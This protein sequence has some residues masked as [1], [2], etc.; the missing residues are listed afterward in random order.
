MGI[1][2][3][4][5]SIQPFLGIDPFETITTLKGETVRDKEGRRTFKVRLG[6]KNYF[7]KYHRGIGWKEIA[8][9][10]AQLRFPIISAYNEYLA[11]TKLQQ[12]GVST[13]NPVAIGVRGINP[14]RTESFL[15]TEAIE[16]AV[17]LEDLT[18]VW[19]NESPNLKFKRALIE[20]V[21]TIARIDRKSVV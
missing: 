3:V 4:D 15:V 21:A 10:L 2:K 1:L 16:N 8:K 9:D 7:I 17:T 13:T 11:I 6:N 20:E 19:P 12:L 5:A 14:A 18:K